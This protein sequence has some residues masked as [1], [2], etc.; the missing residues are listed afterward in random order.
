M[1]A[2]RNGNED[3][4]LDL[5]RRCVTGELPPGTGLPEEETDLLKTGILDSMGWVGVLSALEDATGLTNVGNPWPENLPQ[6]IRSLVRVARESTP[7]S[8]SPLL[9]TKTLE[10]T[11]EKP[12]AVRLGGWGYALGSERIEARRIEEEFGLPAGTLQLQA[13]IETVCRAAAGEDETVLAQRA[14]ESAL[15]VAQVSLDQIRLLVVTSATFLHL[16]G[17]AAT[18]HTRLLLP[19]SCPALDVGGAC[20]GLLQALAAAEAL[21][22]TMPGGMALVVA[23]EMHSRRLHPAGVRG[24]FGGLFGDGACAFVLG[25]SS[26]SAG[27]FGEGPRFGGFVAGCSGTY[28]SSLRLTLQPSGELDVDFKGQQLAGAALSE[29]A[30]VLERLERQ[31]GYSLSAVDYFAVHEPNPRLA[32]LLAPRIKIPPEKIPLVT[33]SCGNLGS[34]TLGVSLCSSLAAWRGRSSPPPPALFFLAAVAP[35]LLWAGTWLNF[36]SEV[37]SPPPM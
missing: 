12:A 15:E 20:V 34:A 23:A 14:A 2:D 24:E 1:S 3:G 27:K 31:S 7:Q 11:A 6:S 10:G 5:V 4:V 33:A 9:E 18:L 19:E 32:R 26:A 8:V 29:L 30:C 37:I 22:G 36:P 13:G 25:Q 21:L 17:L 35:G 16:P 28:S